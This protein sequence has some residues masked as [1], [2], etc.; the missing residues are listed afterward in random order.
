[1]VELWDVFDEHGN[2][3]GKVIR[4]G[5]ELKVGEYMMSVH[6]YLCNLQGEYLIQRRSIKKELLPGVWDVTGGAVISGEDSC[7]AAIREVDEELGI[8]LDKDNL[9]PVLTV[10][11]EH[12][13]ANVWFA[14]ADF[15]LSDCILQAEEVD[16]VRF[17]SSG[18][19]KKLLT[20][21]VYREE[22]YKKLVIE[23]IDWIDRRF[24]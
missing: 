1:M 18:E 21:A 11:R 17:V 5:S 22:D 6:I 3:T 16:E 13:F 23:A 8:K 20:E 7:E 19:M 14:I 24:L 2:K 10:R 15:K 9:F 4:R 12:N